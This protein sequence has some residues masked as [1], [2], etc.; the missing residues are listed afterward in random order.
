MSQ[1]NMDSKIEKLKM[2]SPIDP[3]PLM[4]NRKGED[5]QFPVDVCSYKGSTGDQDTK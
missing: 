5:C 2:P 1:G 3:S 4:Q